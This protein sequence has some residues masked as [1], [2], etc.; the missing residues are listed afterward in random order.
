MPSRTHDDGPT[1]WRAPA[2]FRRVPSSLLHSRRSIAFAIRFMELCLL[3]GILLVFAAGM[4]R[5][6]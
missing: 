5:L 3:A 1:V 6:R 4:M 2:M